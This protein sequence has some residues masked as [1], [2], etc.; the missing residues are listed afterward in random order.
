MPYPRSLADI[1]KSLTNSGVLGNLYSQGDADPNRWTLPANSAPVGDQMARPRGLY[2]SMGTGVS[3]EAVPPGMGSESQPVSAMSIPAPTMRPSQ[4]TQGKI[5]DVLDKDYSIT[6]NKDGTVTKGKDRDE[7]FDY[8]DVLGGAG[9]GAL[10]GFQR[11]G[12]IGGI[13]GAITGATD[14]NTAEKYHDSQTLS[15]LYPK[16]QAQAGMEAQDQKFD[17][18]QTQIGTERA[19]GRNYDNEIANRNVKTLLD[20]DKATQDRLTGEQSNILK[21]WQDLDTYD[22]SKPEYKAL[23]DRAAKAGVELVKKDKG[24]R[25]SATITPNGRL[26]ILNTSTGAVTDEGGDYSKPTH[27]TS[28]DISD[29]FPDLPDDAKLGTMAT[30]SVGEVPPGTRIK[31]AMLAA[32]KQDKSVLDEF[33]EINMPK[34][35]AAYDPNEVFENLPSDYKQRHAQAVLAAGKLYEAK[36]AEITKLGAAVESQKSLQPGG[37][38]KSRNELKQMW[39]TAYSIKDSKKRRQA[40]DDL[41]RTIEAGYLQ[42]Q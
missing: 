28:K 17:L 16:Y 9:L 36:R 32:L 38:T 12:L 27:L 39:D 14:R 30:A 15:R 10:Q 21:V 40:L 6:K 19:Q 3:E 41:Y 24:Q 23:A 18:G 5:N 26:K 29:L 8:K 31:P 22:A 42:V 37:H 1:K 25:Y 35:L 11:G 7:D 20:I 2:P 13:I 34:V 4:T 33:G